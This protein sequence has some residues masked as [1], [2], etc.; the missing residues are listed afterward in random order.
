MMLF[1]IK[2]TLLVYHTILKNNSKNI[3]S[4]NI[5]NPL[6][7]FHLH[8]WFLTAPN[9]SGQQKDPSK[10]AKITAFRFVRKHPVSIAHSMINFKSNSEVT[11]L[12]FAH[13]RNDKVPVLSN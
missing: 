3:S 1:C 5:L 11:F 13:A 2:F 12:L 10:M 4:Q 6:K 8:Q 9:L 7:N